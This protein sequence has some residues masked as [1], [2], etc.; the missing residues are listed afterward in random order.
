VSGQL[1]RVVVAD[2]HPALLGILATYLGDHGYDVVATAA[3]GH[4]A[5]EAVAAEQPDVVVTDYRMPYLQG[6]ELLREL[7][8]A[9][10]AARL[11]VYTGEAS[12]ALWDETRAAGASA[13]VLK[14]APL[15]D[16]LRAIAAVHAGGTY[17]DPGLAAQSLAVGGRPALVLTDR[18]T[19][20]LKLLAE[21]LSHEEIGVQ[22][23]ISAE[24]VRT[25]VRKACDRLG[26]TTRT[27][28]V[29]TALRLG[30][31]S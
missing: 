15:E 20:V 3:D 21:G 4:R 23:S 31:I 8:A 18:E 14:E 12:P 29:A 25:H 19:A 30:L 11:V 1:A 17:L 13:L 24:T 9:C 26:A 22:L 2:D 10:P 7:G 27:Q 5:A 6:A 28:A 16:L